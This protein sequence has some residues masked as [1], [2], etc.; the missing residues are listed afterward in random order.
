M[1]KNGKVKDFIGGI[2]LILLSVFVLAESRIIF[3]KAGKEMHLSPA[4]IPTLL[5]SLLL[6]LSIVLF[7]GS[8]KDG[9]I[10]ARCRELKAMLKENKEDPN[11]PRMLI[12]LC[13]MALYTFVLLGLLPFWL[14]T[15]IFL[16]ALMKYLGAGSLPK[17]VIISV[18]VTGLIIVLFQVLFRVPLP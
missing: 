16:V 1:D 14:S 3:V 13:F 2:V 7:L 5:G 4:L 6:I 17:I 12:G 15:V 11:T 9:G 18:V 8:L 10:S